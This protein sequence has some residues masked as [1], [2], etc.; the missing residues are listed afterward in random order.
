MRPG[1]T[2]KRQDVE[3]VYRETAKR[4]GLPRAVCSDGAVELREPAENLGKQGHRPLVLRDP[5]HF[6]ANQFEALLK[7]DPQ[8]QAFANQLAGTRSAVQQTELCA[9]C[10]ARLQDQVSV[11]E[12]AT[13][14]NLGVRRAVASG[15]SEI[16]KPPGH[17][18]EPHGGKAGLAA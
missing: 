18:P 14:V 7:G 8:Y 10:P 9:L 1:E 4:Y 6:L 2:W 3:Q 16:E 11:Y 15:P 17:L 13:D 5:K 12:S